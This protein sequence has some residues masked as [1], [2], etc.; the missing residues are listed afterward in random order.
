MKQDDP[1]RQ[2]GGL[3][4]LVTWCTYGDDV[5]YE[6]KYVSTTLTFDP[7]LRSHL[8]TMDVYE[9]ADEAAVVIIF[10]SICW[11]MIKLF[12]VEFW[13]I[14]AA[15]VVSVAYFLKAT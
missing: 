7:S 15:C 11:R 2:S 9:V 14:S 4:R 8:Y 12:M 6:P 1:E 10:V 5:L 3:G 13:R